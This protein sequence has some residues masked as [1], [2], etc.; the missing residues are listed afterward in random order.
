MIETGSILRTAASWDVL[1]LAR[2]VYET[3]RQSR[4]K[5]T[6][7][8]AGVAAAEQFV[9][10]V[11]TRYGFRA[12]DFSIAWDGGDFDASRDEHELVITSKDGRRA[13]A[14]IAGEALLRSDA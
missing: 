4:K 14:R 9:K 11:A 3:D 8:P 6:P 2:H 1:A 12:Q 13:A 5:H 7:Q 10:S